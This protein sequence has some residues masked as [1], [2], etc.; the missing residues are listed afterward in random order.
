LA[1][2]PPLTSEISYKN[3][4]F[5]QGSIG[6]GGLRVKHHGKD[7]VVIETAERKRD[8]LGHVDTFERY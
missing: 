7:V 2:D 8:I 6:E 4:F 5:G 3:H 1:T